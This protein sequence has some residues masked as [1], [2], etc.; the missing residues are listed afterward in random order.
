M[1]E[2]QGEA[3]WINA[4]CAQRWGPAPASAWRGQVLRLHR[5]AYLVAEK[6]QIRRIQRILLVG[7]LAANWPAALTPAGRSS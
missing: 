6:P 1:Y 4:Y 7:S 2:G 3:N 5:R